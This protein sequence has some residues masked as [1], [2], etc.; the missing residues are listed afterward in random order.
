M[1]LCQVPRRRYVLKVHPHVYKCTKIMLIRNKKTVAAAIRQPPP[2]VVI[3]GKSYLN[4]SILSMGF[5]ALRAMSAGTS[6]D[7]QPYFRVL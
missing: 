4:S 6:T 1:S 5:T 3:V 2:N 7:G